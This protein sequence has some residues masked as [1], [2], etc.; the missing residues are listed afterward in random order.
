MHKLK[1]ATKKHNFEQNRLFTS[2]YIYKY[3]KISLNRLKVIKHR[4]LHDQNKSL[5]LE[6]LYK[7]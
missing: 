4:Q 2:K 6:T 5:E 1:I 3:R 7:D